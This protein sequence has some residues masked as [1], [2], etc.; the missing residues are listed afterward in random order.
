MRAQ[1]EMSGEFSL[2]RVRRRLRLRAAEG[3]VL[4]VLMVVAFLVGVRHAHEAQAKAGVELRE[5]R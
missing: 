3:V 4:G 2:P 1:Q 5:A